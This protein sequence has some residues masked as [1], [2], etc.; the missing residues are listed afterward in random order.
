M[1]PALEKVSGSLEISPD[2]RQLFVAHPDADSVSV[3]DLASRSV[4]HQVLLAPAAPTP[5]AKG[6]YAPAVGPRA[7]AHAVARHELEIELERV[8][9]HLAQPADLGIDVEHGYQPMQTRLPPWT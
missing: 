7:L 5:D 3:I 6:R 4:V 8:G 2:G 1:P 9:D